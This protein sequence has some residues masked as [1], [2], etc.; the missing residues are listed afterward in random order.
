MW[1][2]QWIVWLF[3]LS[4][5]V[6]VRICRSNMNNH[7]RVACKT[8]NVTAKLFLPHI[9]IINYCKQKRVGNSL[10]Y[11]CNVI[12]R[13]YHNSCYNRVTSGPKDNTT[14]ISA[15]YLKSNN[16][17]GSCLVQWRNNRHGYP[18]KARGR[19]P[20]GAPNSYIFESWLYVTVVFLCEKPLNWQ[21]FK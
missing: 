9:S 17:L 12:C 15:R 19:H 5:C 7:A 21:Y 16:S 20:T 18:G 11:T 2:W 1:L 6:C 14:K 8:V 4:V 10:W 3:R 13:L